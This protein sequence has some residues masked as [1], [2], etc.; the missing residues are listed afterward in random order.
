M[1]RSASVVDWDARR[2]TEAYPALEVTILDFP[3]VAALG[4]TYV[5]EAGLSERITYREG[6]ALSSDWPVGVDA[7]LMSYLFSCV[8]GDAH[9]GA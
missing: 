5:A 4:R 3:N 6:N 2:V 9:P 1:K 8:P 7:V